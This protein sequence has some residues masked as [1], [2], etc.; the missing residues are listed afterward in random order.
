MTTYSLSA[1]MRKWFTMGTATLIA[2]GGLAVFGAGQASAATN[3]WSCSL[4]QSIA[5]KTVTS[6]CVALTGPGMDRSKTQHRAAAYCAMERGR[7]NTHTINTWVQGPWKPFG[8]NS[9]V[10]CPLASALI[11]GKT[12]L[13]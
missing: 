6:K 12:E 13:R 10:T 3:G 1:G 8:Q 5:K 4:D 7:G 11:I 2:A 9:S